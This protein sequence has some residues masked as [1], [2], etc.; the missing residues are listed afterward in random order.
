MA[1]DEFNSGARHG[2]CMALLAIRD[3]EE[4]M[5]C[6]ERKNFSQED[7]S[8]EYERYNTKKDLL[9]KIKKEINKEMELQ[10]YEDY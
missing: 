2:F 9:Y 6:P 4:G 7:W 10:V 1:R 5:K 3:I 8:F